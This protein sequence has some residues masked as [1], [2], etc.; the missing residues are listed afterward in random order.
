MSQAVPDFGP[1][2]ESPQNVV[3]TQFDAY[4]ERNLDLFCSCFSPTIKTYEFQNETPL[5]SGLDALREFY[6][7]K[8]FIHENLHCKLIHRAVKGNK[9]IDHEIITMGDQTME[10]VAIY[11]VEQS[12]IQ[13]V[14]FIR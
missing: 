6:K 7:T 13:Q 2:S 14:W 1:M 9:V 5:V 3:Q 11:E 10:L 8:R 12:L 4:N